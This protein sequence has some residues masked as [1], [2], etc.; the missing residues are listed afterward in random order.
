LDTIQT[1]N[2]E[3]NP[4][5]NKHLSNVCGPLDENLKFIENKLCVKISCR[6]NQFKIVGEHKNIKTTYDLLNKLYKESLNGNLN[7]TKNYI[8]DAIH[9]KQHPIKTNSMTQNKHSLANHI[10]TNKK[11]IS[12]KTENQK[13]LINNLNQH[14]VNFIIGPAGTGKTFLAAAF[15]VQML[16]QGNIDRITLVRPAIE[17][18][19]KL[20]FLPGS[21][22]E[23]IDPYLRPLYDSLFDLT[24]QEQVAR[25]IE[26][27][28]IE[29]APLAYMRGRTLNNSVIILDEAQNTSIAQ[30][31]MFLTRL[32]FN[33]R[34]IITGDVSQ[35]DL[36]HSIKSGLLHANQILK[37]IKN[38][39][40]T[41]LDG[42]DVI[43][44]PLLKEIIKAYEENEKPS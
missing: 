5:D 4:A 10:N 19:E 6:G 24:T 43:R 11:I 33:S 41:Y 38:I 32:G 22:E 18:G 16:E 31:K 2:I 15:A 44:H 1:T 3:L 13:E 34:A 42:H 29:L 26:K 40:F 25:Y 37:N 17:A 23:K 35:I 8:S 30:M 27:G 7:I 9:D 39:G 28:V 36:P 12:P 14:D 21:L 20:G